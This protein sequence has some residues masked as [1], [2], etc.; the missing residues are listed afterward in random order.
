MQIA[1]QLEALNPEK[2]MINDYLK[3]VIEESEV[4]LSTED[5]LN[6]TNGHDFRC[7]MKL[8]CDCKIP[9]RKLNEDAIFWSLLCAYRMNDFFKT[10]LFR[11]LVEYETSEKICIINHK[12]LLKI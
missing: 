2:T 3:A 5:L 1:T 11:K 12:S 8:Y 4:G 7:C 6:I 9:K 10:D